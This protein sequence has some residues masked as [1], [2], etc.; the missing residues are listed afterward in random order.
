MCLFVMYGLRTWLPKIMQDAGFPLGS[1]LTF[2]LALNIGAVVGAIVG[3]QL[4][5]C[6]GTKK[7]LVIFFLIAFVSLTV[8][9]FKPSM[10]LFYLLIALAAGTTTGTQIVANSYSIFHC[11]QTS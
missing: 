11:R 1:S 8:L 5:D 9:S 6:F 7:T 10:V 4:A 3:G 2:L